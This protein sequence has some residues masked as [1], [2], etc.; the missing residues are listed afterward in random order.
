MLAR[1]SPARIP[2]VR[3][4]AVLAGTGAY[5]LFVKLWDPFAPHAFGCPFH[6]IT[7]LWCPGCGSTRAAYS[8][9]HGQVVDAFRYNLLVPLGLLLVAAVLFARPRRL[10]MRWVCAGVV[11]VMVF[12]VLRNLPA[13]GFFAPVS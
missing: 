13:F 7:G 8:L 9:M 6:A 3:V 12:A 1:L 5:A 11:G 4:A 2:G 10:P